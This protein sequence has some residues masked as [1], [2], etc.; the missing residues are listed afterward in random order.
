MNDRVTVSTEDGVADV[1]FVRTDKMNALD[2]KMFE[3]IIEAGT[4][5]KSDKH[6]RAVVLS[7]E[8][9]AFCA[10]LDMGNFQRTADAGTDPRPEDA[11]KNV[12]A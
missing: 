8:G 11:L 6:V 4:T 5:L 9:K 12:Y 3:A 2:D 7:G 10:G 1:R